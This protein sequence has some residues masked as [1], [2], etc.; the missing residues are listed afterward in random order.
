MVSGES[1]GTPLWVPFCS[2]GAAAV[3]LVVTVD[4]AG[5]SQL[6]GN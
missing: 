1:L 2:M 6:G 3:L 5:R 4:A